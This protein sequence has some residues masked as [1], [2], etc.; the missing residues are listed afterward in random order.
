MSGTQRRLLG[1][2]LL[3][4]ACLPTSLSAQEQTPEALWEDFNHYVLIAKPD[5]ALATGQTLLKLADNQTLLATVESSDREAWVNVLA[6]AAKMGE[7]DEQY[8]SLVN[9]ANDLDK[10]I[11]AA[12]VELSRNPERIQADIALLAQ[13]QRAY[14]NATQRLAAAGQYAAP[15]L[16]AALLDTDQSRLHPYILSAMVTIGQPLVSPLSAALPQLDPVSMSQVAQ[17]LAEI[18]YPQALPAMKEVLESPTADADA[19]LAVQAAYSSLLSSTR[20]ASDLSAAEWNLGLG[21]TQYTT[22]TNNGDDLAGYDASIESGLVWVYGPKIGLV[23]VVVPGEI[24][25]DVLAMRSAK[26]ALELNDGLDAA[27]SLYLM[28]NLR[29]ENRLPSGTVDPSYPSELQPAGF[30]AMLSGPDRLHDVL[31]QATSDGDAELA[32]D[33]IK[34]LAATA[35]TDALVNRGSA[36]Q[37]LMTALSYPDRRV[38]FRAAEA[39][40]SVRPTEDFPGAHRVIAVLAEAVRQSDARYA[41]VLADDQ[42]TVNGLLAILHELGFEAFGGLS[43]ADVSVELNLVPGVDL[44][45]AAVDSEMIVRIYHDTANDYKTGTVP[46]LALQTLE[47]QIRLGNALGETTRVSRAVISDDTQALS[48]AVEAAVGTFRGDNIDA[49]QSMQFALTALRLLREVAVCSPIFNIAEAQPA[50]IQALSDE[51]DEIKVASAAA[52]ALIDSPD[53][54]NALAEAALSLE[55]DL[56]LSM[57][58]SLAD[59]A[60]YFGSHLDAGQTDRLLELVNTGSGDLAIAASRAHGAL[61]LPTANAVKLLTQ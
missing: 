2:C 7:A 22:A 46:I 28:A 20:Q 27:L 18:G 36:Q 12:R 58:A 21:Q 44:I 26:R 42:D 33:A 39:L 57:L 10:R 6:R 38:R 34:A 54:Q 61:S 50:L 59:S 4:S 49:E 19:R 48:G 8:A 43:M 24:F 32:L 51:R 25:G 14:R 16:L 40:A 41:L 15:Q 11:Q 3:V 1:L 52:L 35:G 30:Y 37:P 29:R 47:Q 56:Q 17:V 23:P 60:T 5:L 31:A 55:G 45:V 13:G 9:V 53:T